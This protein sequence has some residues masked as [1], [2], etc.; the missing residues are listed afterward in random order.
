MGGQALLIWVCRQK[1]NEHCV[2]AIKR[3]KTYGKRKGCLD[4]SEGDFVEEEALHLR[5]ADRMD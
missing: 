3:V 5:L 1:R 4:E 2:V